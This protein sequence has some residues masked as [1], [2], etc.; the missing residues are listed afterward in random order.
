MEKSKKIDVKAILRWIV[1]LPAAGIA[2][3]LA[4]NIVW[5]VQSFTTWIFVGSGTVVEIYFVRFFSYLCM[6]MATV[7]VACFVAPSFKKGIAVVMG[8]LILILSGATMFYALSVPEYL[9]IVDS[10]AMDL[11]AIGIATAIYNEQTKLI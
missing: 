2:G 4:Y 5:Y 3:F 7:Y 8:G 6:G 9:G 10:V 11:G 1:F